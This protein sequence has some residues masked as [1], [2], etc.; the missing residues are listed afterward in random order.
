MNERITE[1][2]LEQFQ[3]EL[4]YEEKA[5]LTIEKYMRD[6]R[7]FYSFL[8]EKKMVTQESVLAYKEYLKENYSLTSANSMIVAL[9][10]FLEYGGWGDMRIRQ[11]KIQKQFFCQGKE[12]RLTEA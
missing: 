6:I 5:K 9:N 11:F 3:K 2:L 1:A 8:P 7:K 12:M 4:E 10:A